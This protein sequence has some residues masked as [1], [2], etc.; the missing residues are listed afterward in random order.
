MPTLSRL[1]CLILPIAL[2]GCD[3]VYIPQSL[4]LRGKPTAGTQ[5]EFDIKIISLNQNAV[6]KA[7]ETPYSRPVIS[8]NNLNGPA[9]TRSEKS[10]V[11]ERWPTV[12][13]PPQ[14]S[15]GPGDILSVSWQK[16]EVTTET[17]ALTAFKKQTVT[18]G[19][20]G[21]ITFD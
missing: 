9:V 21:S 5:Q 10:T 15:L 17:T 1:C 13:R 3:G 11:S 19:P 8:G 6:L 7:N 18:I 2:I 12:T 14:Y 20:D 16:P 4:P